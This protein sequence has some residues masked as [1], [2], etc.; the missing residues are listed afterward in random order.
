MKRIGVAVAGLVVLSKCGGNGEA[1]LGDAQQ[2]L[3][4]A[5]SG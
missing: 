4:S 3:E 5:G 2:A 1:D